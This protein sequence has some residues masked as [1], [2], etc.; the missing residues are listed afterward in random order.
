MPG[1]IRLDDREGLVRHFNAVQAKRAERKRG[2]SDGPTW[3]A[4]GG[5][6]PRDYGALPLG[7]LQD[8]MRQERRREQYRRDLGT[9]TLLHTGTCKITAK[10]IK[11]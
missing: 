5:R 7:E 8:L 3:G 1:P 11:R 10:H 9:P 4:K 6:V 2:R